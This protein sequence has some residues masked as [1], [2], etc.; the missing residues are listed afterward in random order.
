MYVK[1]AKNLHPNILVNSKNEINNN[2]LKIE[3]TKSNFREKQE[4]KTS[5]EKKLKPELPETNTIHK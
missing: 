1:D 2:E 5:N 4:Q 3:Y